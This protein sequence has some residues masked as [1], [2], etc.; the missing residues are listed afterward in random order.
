ALAWYLQ[1][2]GVTARH[3]GWWAGLVLGAALLFTSSLNSHGA[4]A[5]QWTAL[6]I[7]MDWVHLVATTI[8]VGGLVQ[9]VVALP[10]ALSAL[11]GA[12]RGRLLAAI[13]P[14]FS[15]WALDAVG[16]LVI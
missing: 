3:R 16:A 7:T 9:L 1:R 8:W 6:A 15:A 4:A 10:A 2:P 12:G 14:R 5:Q 11:G 13:I